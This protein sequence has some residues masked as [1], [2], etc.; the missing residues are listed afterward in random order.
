MSVVLVAPGRALPLAFQIDAHFRGDAEPF[1]LRGSPATT[2]RIDAALAKL[3]YDLKTVRVEG[4]Y[5]PPGEA[6]PRQTLPGWADESQ[7]PATVSSD[8]LARVVYQMARAF[9]EGF[10]P[11]GTPPE[12][13]ITT[14]A[15]TAT[16][17]KP[18]QKKRRKAPTV[19]RQT[20]YRD[21]ETGYYVSKEKWSRERK[22][23]KKGKRGRYVRVRETRIT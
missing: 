3:P 20:R 17:E 14:I 15:V 23:L 12:V 16:G 10:G 5:Q 4:F 9:V 18:P 22:R 1:M 7:V 21:R 11:R 2:A 6:R 8:T 13:Y 19:F